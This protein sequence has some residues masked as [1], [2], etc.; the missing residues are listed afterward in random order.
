MPLFIPRHMKNWKPEHMRRKPMRRC[1]W[2]ANG[3]HLI[4]RMVLVLESPMRFHFCS[5]Q[6][7]DRWRL[8]RHDEAVVEWLRLAAGIRAEILKELRDEA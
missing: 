6:C 7:L 1:H 5:D 2:C 3:P 8:H 4:G